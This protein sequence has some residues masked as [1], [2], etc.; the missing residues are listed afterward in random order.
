M[1]SQFSVNPLLPSERAS[2]P[3]I[4]NASADAWNGQVIPRKVHI[5]KLVSNVKNCQIPILT[6][7]DLRHPSPNIAVRKLHVAICT[8]LVDCQDFLIRNQ[9]GGRPVVAGEIATEN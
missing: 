3:E 1:W 9:R 5:C 8:V 6:S 2:P 4:A 7:G